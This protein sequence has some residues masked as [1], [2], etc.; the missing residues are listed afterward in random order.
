VGGVIKMIMAM[1]HGTL[2]PTLHADEP[3]PHVDW[4]SGEIRLLTEPEPWETGDRPRRA[5]VSSFGISGTNAHVILEEAPADATVL[6]KGSIA[7]TGQDSAAETVP[8]LVSAKSESALREQAERLRAHVE[9]H[10]ELEL[11]DVAFTLATARAQLDR[12]AAVVGSD[13]D[14]LLAGLDALARGEPAAGVVEGAPAGGKTAFMFTG[15]GAQRVGMGREL[16]EAFPAFAEAFDAVCGELGD[17]L[18]E[19]TFAGNEEELARTENTQSALFAIEVALYRLLESWGLKPDFLIGHSIGELAAAHVAGVLSLADACK[20]VAARGR[21]MGALPADG[22]MVAIEATEEE[23]TANLDPS[24]S[25]AAVNAPRSTVVSGDATAIEKLAKEWESKDRR[26]SKLRVSHAFHSQLMEP[27]LDEFRELA[28]SLEYEPP[29]IPIVSNLTGELADEIASPDYWVRHVREPVRFAD[30]IRHLETQGVTRYLELGPDGVLSAMAAQ[31]IEADALLVPTLRKDRPDTEAL[32][33]FL[34]EAHV[35]G[36]HIDWATVLKNGRRV[37][38]P[39]YAFQRERF[40]LSAGAGASDLGA[41]GLGASEHPLLGASVPLAGA[42]GWLFTGRLSLATDPWLADHVVL[43]TVLLPGTAFVELALAAGRESGCETLE[44]L[45]LEAPLVLPDAGAVQLQVTVEESDESGRRRVA[46]HSRPDEA[47]EDAAAPR[48][49]TRHA[50]GAIAPADVDGD[51]DGDQPM[52]AWPPEGA[53]PI[54]VEFLYDRLAEV[55]FDYGPAFQGVSAAWRR[56]DELFAEI[57]LEDAQTDEAARFGV[58]PAL[59]DS[60]LHV[61][62]VDKRLEP[63]KLPLPFSWEG[64]R[65]HRSG[66]PSLRVRVVLAGEDALSIVA[67]D[68]TGAPVLSV[69]SLATRPVDPSQLRSR[70]PGAHAPLYR[71]DWVEVSPPSTNGHLD[72]LAALGDLHAFDVEDRYADIAALGA[73]IE[74]GAPAPD[75]VLVATRTDSRGDDIPAATR[76]AVQRALDLLQA[77]LADERLAESRLVFVT[78]GAMGVA[79]DELPDLPGAAV[80]GLVRSAQS[81]NPGRFLLVDVDDAARGGEIAWPVLL[82]ADEPQLALRGDSTYALRL[83]PL[84]EADTLLPPAGERAWRL[85][86]ER[87]GTLEDLALIESTR[88]KAALGPD[89]IRVAV[90]AAGLNFRDVLIALGH[91]PGEDPIGSEGAGLV[92]EVGDGV[93]DLALGDRV[94]GLMGDAFGP[95]AVTDRRLV[96][97]MPADWSFVQAAAVPLVFLTAY[98]GLVDLAEL[99]SGEKVLVHAGAGGVGMAAIQIARHIGAEV[100]ATASPDKWDALREL[101]IDDHHIGSSRDLDFRERFLAATDGAGMDVVLDALAREFVDATLELLPRGGRFIEMGKTDIRDADEVGATHP[102]VRY[103][104]FD[105]LEAGP[106]RITDMLAELLELFER[107][108]LGCPPIQTWDVRRG[109]EA[110]RHLREAKHVGKVVLTVPRLLDPNGTVLITGGTGGLGALVA[111]HLVTEDG[112]RR[113]LLVSRRGPKAEG[114]AELAAELGELGAEASVMACDVAD[115][116]QLSKLLGSIPE[117]HPL[118]AVFHTAGVLDDGVIESLTAKQVDRVMLPKVDAG[119]SLHELTEGMDLAEFVLFSSDS[120]T[121]GAPGQG[122]YAA[123][124]VFLD[125]LAHRRRAQG[126]A[127]KSMAWGLWSNASGMAGSLDEADVERLARLGIVALSDELELFDTARG[128]ADALVV[129][130]RLDLAVLRSRA[131]AGTLPAVMR[132]LVRAPARRERDARG[133]LEQQLAGVPEAEREGVVLEVVL[134]QA[135]VVLGHGSA[136]SVDPERAFKDLGFDSLGA[137]EFRNRLAQTTGMRLPSTLIFDYPSPTAVAGYLLKKASPRTATVAPTNGAPGEDEVRK[138]LASIPLE[139]LREAGLFDQLV[140]LA[141]TNDD[142]PTDGEAPADEDESAFDEMDA[143]DLVRMTFDGADSDPEAEEDS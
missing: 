97:R 118:T 26:T 91:Y 96:A 133:S 141:G 121:I 23:V 68:S 18:K 101:G 8:W 19:L 90:R 113:L 27:M 74:S 6:P 15:Q 66:A 33:G 77:W 95:V 13:R 92:L 12:R 94:M 78:R 41:A 131:Q 123:A 45:T 4:S 85:G 5:A 28:A 56:G 107:G 102:G 138:A 135:A 65:L 7:T 62:L 14:A 132:G 17:G 34:A 143:E 49:W 80:W 136:N 114:A 32:T 108:E 128:A 134:N 43:D 129:P 76:E 106:E 3:S 137:V 20:L 142:V 35:H 24:L 30:G 83:A 55:G 71:H 11:L 22:A 25:I 126:L 88:G 16:Y 67:A 9:A 110:F 87:K 115:R 31:T 117:E 1:R 44:E 64:V 93:S 139:R 122:N 125:A 116:E 73:A 104:A 58:H 38:L 53:E 109:I 2:P 54:E 124:N 81:E 82:A 99:R 84:A 69:R 86:A 21:L 10:A 79:E 140:R 103:R 57:G 36:A 47:G 105:L 46:V 61:G 112:A 60:I 111:R 59:F 39:T 89:E 98:Y 120:G 119:L 29:R 130:T 42:E 51:D 72:R 127:A 100:Y 48:P 37:K 75:A 40:W 63:D 70:R 50:S 52:G